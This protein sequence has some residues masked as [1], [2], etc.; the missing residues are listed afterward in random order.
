MSNITFPSTTYVSVVFPNNYSTCLNPEDTINITGLKQY[1]FDTLGI[2]YKPY[3]MV[4]VKCS[5]GL[6]VCM[7]ACVDVTVPKG[8]SITGHVVALIN[9]DEYT[10]RLARLKKMQKIKNEL[11]ARRKQFEST[12]IYEL[13]AAKDPVVADLLEQYK[14]YTNMEVSQ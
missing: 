8:V 7:I 2:H 4:V 1:T 11:E 6:Q 14:S 3:D 13:M 9:L 5:Q 10:H 12:Q